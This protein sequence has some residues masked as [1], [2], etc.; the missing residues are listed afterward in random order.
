MLLRTVTKFFTRLR[1]TGPQS[2]GELL[3]RFLVERNEAAFDV[4]VRRHSAMVLRVCQRVLQQ[5]QDAED[6]FQATFIV[7]ARKAPSISKQDSLASWLHGVAYRIAL[8]ARTTAGRRRSHEKRAGE[9]ASVHDASGEHGGTM[10][11]ELGSVLDEELQHLPEKYRT[12]LLLC[13]FE[14]KTNQEAA[15]QL[16]WPM[17]TI[18]TRLSQG[19]ELLRQRLSRRGL[20]YS[21]S[22][23]SAVL[24]QDA[25][26][27]AVPPT[28]VAS[29]IK[30]AAL[31]AVG[32]TAPTGLLTA[33]AVAQAETALAS[34]TAH[35]WKLAAALC[36]AFLSLGSAATALA[37]LATPNQL[38]RTTASDETLGFALPRHGHTGP[39]AC[40]AF[41]ADGRLLASGSTDG[42]VKLWR[43]DGDG[44]GVQFTL[45]VGAAVNA[46]ALSRDGRTL[47]AAHGRTVQL[48]DL[49]SLRLRH[50]LEHLEPVTCLAFRADGGTLAAGC[51]SLDVVMQPKPGYG[52]HEWD[53]RTGE[54]KSSQQAHHRQGVCALVYAANGTLNTGGA[55]YA[56]TEEERKLLEIAGIRFVALA[57][58]PDGSRLAFTRDRKSGDAFPVHLLERSK[59]ANHNGVIYGHKDDLVR[60][61]AFSPDGKLLAS[62]STKVMVWNLAENRKQ[63]N[64]SPGST[65]VSALAFSADGQR[66]AVA[67]GMDIQLWD[68][69][70][71]QW[72]RTL[73][74][75]SRPP[76]G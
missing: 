40:T 19:R 57:C 50:K 47:A 9:L 24:V 17:G 32:H 23:L 46:L 34:M 55:D 11:R 20:A 29:T 74:G 54:K 66:I 12:P 41:S 26:T 21:A 37:W 33:E 51:G 6:A 5:R 44:D 64:F 18:A 2:D 35:Q 70:T 1:E 63:V 7:L 48:W 76:G 60:A 10:S 22:G 68:V 38:A 69:A 67:V 16:G 8:K 52:V 72:R 53:T 28:L 71:G 14:G 39:V 43:V 62:A 56:S 65:P 75:H 31:L 30:G 58:S 59:S 42:T 4:L 15:Q 49:P 45:P 25:A 3:Q 36:L 73:A 13:Y 61:V 27:A